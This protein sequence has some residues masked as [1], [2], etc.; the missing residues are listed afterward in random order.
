LRISSSWRTG[1]HPD[2]ALAKGPKP[3]FTS[4]Y[5]DPNPPAKSGHLISLITGGYINQPSL[6]S[7]GS[8]GRLGGARGG[9]GVGLGGGLGGLL[10]DARGGW[11]DRM[12]GRGNIGGRPSMERYGFREDPYASER[13]DIGPGVGA[14]AGRGGQTGRGP[15][16]LGGLPIS[17]QMI[18]RVL[19]KV[20]RCHFGLPL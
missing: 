5:A 7:E 13:G 1:K 16:G 2:S 8:Q 11:G 20:S 14:G 6:G 4:R 17:P 9:F 3:T 12:S 19:K 18:E 10:G 15:T